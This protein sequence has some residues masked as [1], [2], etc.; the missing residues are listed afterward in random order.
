MRINTHIVGY[1]ES[2]DIHV[3]RNAAGQVIDL[4]PVEGSERAYL[5]LELPGGTV[6]QAEIPHAKLDDVISHASVSPQR[7]TSQPCECGESGRNE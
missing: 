5:D 3:E 4:N 2:R 6:L 1:K 7:E